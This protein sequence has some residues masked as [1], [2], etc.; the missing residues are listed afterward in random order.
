[1]HSLAILILLIVLIATTGKMVY[2]AELFRH[3]AR[4]PTH[5]IYDGKDT[6]PFHGQL[7]GTGMRQ[8][9]LLGSYLRKD[10]LEQLGLSPFFNGRQVEVISDGTQRCVESAYAHMAGCYPLG[11]GPNIP[12]GLDP[13]FL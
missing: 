12:L 6:K 8:Q 10:Y 3:G 11:S 13:A 2:M 5:D 7:I 1:M 9:Y 4:Y